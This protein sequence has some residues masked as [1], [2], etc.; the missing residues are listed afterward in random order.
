M[1]RWPT[2]DPVVERRF[3]HGLSGI[4]RDL[5]GAV[6]DVYAERLFDYVLSSGCDPKAVTDVVHDAFIDAYRR[7][8]RMRDRGR[9]RPWL[10]GAARRRSIQRGRTGA[11]SWDWA[12][13]PEE[14]AGL[15]AEQRR[16]LVEDTVG[17]LEHLDQEILVLAVRH[18]LSAA[19]LSAALGLPPRRVANRVVQARG[20]LSV[21]LDAAI[22]ELDQ[23]CGCATGPD[24]CDGCARRRRI[25]PEL[26]FDLPPAP[27]LPVA[28]RHRVMHTATDPE[29]A[30][31]RAD[32]AARGG[33][34]TSDG[35]PRQ[36][37]V[38]SQAARRWMVLT[39]AAMGTVAT[40]MVAALV[41]GSGVADVVWP[42]A[43]HPDPGYTLTGPQAA[44]RTDAQPPPLDGRSGGGGYPPQPA[45]PA[46]PPSGTRPT[47]PVTPTTADPT[48]APGET[49]AAPPP[50]SPVP[51]TPVM[52]GE[53]Q[54]GPATV[55]L[56]GDKRGA[57]VLTAVRAAVTWSAATSTADL[58]L[59][60]RSGS[61]AAGASVTL[62]IEL[63]VKLI[64]L[65]GEGTVTV[66]DG[67]GVQRS[68]RVIW[69]LNML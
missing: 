22:S 61:L 25:T 2:V 14:A 63:S 69:G 16:R 68:V 27:V 4:D 35:L 44:D 41:L 1:A 20:R 47:E 46:L 17:R 6:Y 60:V 11:L 33:A 64:T 28:L 67:G 48:L 5:L 30:G 42:F 39:G 21:L 15:T 54:V 32:I 59:S 40:A 19:D 31:H 34:L 26:L 66:T 51:T 38:P 23:V 53:L 62:H 57:I 58:R 65:P 10:Y 50:S 12:A 9:L 18:D 8:A 45:H 3:V 29:L 56:G 36:P 24:G 55:T 52:A 7:A 43:P 49:P 13:E 37:D